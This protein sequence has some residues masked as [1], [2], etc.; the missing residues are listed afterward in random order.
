MPLGKIAVYRQT[1][2]YRDNR[3]IFGTASMPFNIVLFLLGWNEIACRSALTQTI[4]FLAFRPSQISERC[5]T[6]RRFDGTQ[7]INPFNWIACACRS[8]CCASSIS[9]IHTWVALLCATHTV[10]IYT[11]K[12]LYSSEQNHRIYHRTGAVS[13]IIFM[14]GASW[15][16]HI[17]SKASIK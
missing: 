3:P 17:W 13:T 12:G 15:K 10:I 6:N 16:V 11:V 7:H 8:S 2:Y 5:L 14:R 4:G 1:T 9:S